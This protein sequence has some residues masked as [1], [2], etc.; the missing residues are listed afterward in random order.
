MHHFEANIFKQLKFTDVIL[1]QN[2]L[3]GNYLSNDINFFL[4]SIIQNF[5]S[6]AFC[7]S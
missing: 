5:R 4:S 7:R 2:S 3:L 1:G 6:I